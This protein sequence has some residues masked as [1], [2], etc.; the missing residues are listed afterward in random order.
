MTQNQ[1]Q[2]KTTV[3]LVRH[4]TNDWVTSGKLAGR[5]PD[6]H[7]SQQ[8]DAQAEALGQRLATH[9]IHAVYS[10]PLER[11]LETA[12][13]IARPHGL[14]VQASPG[15]GEVDFGDWTGQQLKELAKEPYWRLVQTRPS[16][17]RFPNGESV[18][19]MQTRAVDEVERLAAAHEGDTIALVS[20]ADVIKAI[21]AHFLGLHLDLFQ[22]LAI[23]PASISSLSFSHGGPLVTTLNDTAHLPAEEAE[24]DR[25][26]DG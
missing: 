15:I 1:E 6:V 26:D 4:A 19:Q 9:P 14:T 20:H 12:A 10:S 21:V 2:P 11:S 17:V 24:D 3:L 23:S 5:A 13:A 22:R 18:R 8:G 25:G 16:L 7:L